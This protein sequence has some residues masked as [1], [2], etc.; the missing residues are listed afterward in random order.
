MQDYNYDKISLFKKTGLTKEPTEISAE[1]ASAGNW[2][3][4]SQEKYCRNLQICV[5]DDANGVVSDVTIYIGKII[6]E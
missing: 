4:V 5:Q 1:I 2:Y 3:T 6:A